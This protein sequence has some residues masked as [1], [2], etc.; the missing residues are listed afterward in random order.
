M[1]P[2]LLIDWAILGLLGVCVLVWPTQWVTDDQNR[3]LRAVT[4]LGV[5][6]Q[7]AFEGLR[8]ELIGAYAVALLFAIRLIPRKGE[9][10]PSAVRESKEST[11]ATSMRW[12]MVLGS[13]LAISISM[14]ALSGVIAI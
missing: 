2:W 5:I 6:A 1:S 7:L 3:W 12:A 8:I 14:L 11:G 13:A 4:V 9:V 10:E